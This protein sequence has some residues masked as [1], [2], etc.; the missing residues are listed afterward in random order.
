LRPGFAIDE[1]LDAL[2]TGL[3]LPPSAEAN[4]EKIE[5]QLPPIHVASH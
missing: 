1:P 5:K 4:R 2:G 3:K